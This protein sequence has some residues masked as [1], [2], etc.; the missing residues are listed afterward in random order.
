M[1]EFTFEERLEIAR[2]RR[3]L[4]GAA[5]LSDEQVLVI[6]DPGGEKT[7]D[8]DMSKL[9]DGAESNEALVSAVL[10][11]SVDSV[12]KFIQKGAD[13][14]QRGTRSNNAT[15]LMRCLDSYDR[16]KCMPVENVVGCMQALLDGRADVNLCCADGKTALHR[17]FAL[18]LEPV[19]D[20]LIGFGAVAKRCSGGSCQ[21]CILS[22]KLAARRKPNKSSQ[23]VRKPRE[24]AQ[25]AEEERKGSYE[26]VLSEEFGDGGECRAAALIANATAAKPS[27]ASLAEACPLHGLEHTLSPS[28][29]LTDCWW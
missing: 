10:L 25:K 21:K 18:Q 26:R 13:V 11:G 1:P 23:V 12:T 4:G 15:L 7:A 28:L 29:S 16:N 14:D 27:T 3:V 24:A 6:A 8:T 22:H 2:R 17:A 9:P 5:I 19:A 20:V